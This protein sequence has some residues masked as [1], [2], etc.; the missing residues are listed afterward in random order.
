MGQ[1]VKLN[2]LDEVLADLDYPIDGQAAAS[3]LDDVTL[4]LS[5]GQENLGQTIRQSSDEEF[6]SPEDLS[7]EV[8][9]LLPRHAVGDPYQ[10]EGEG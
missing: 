9:N 5:D 8:M 7:S 4:Q 3:A 2:Q 1:T 10:S 6:E